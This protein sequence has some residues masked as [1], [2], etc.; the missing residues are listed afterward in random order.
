M[1]IRC[2]TATEALEVAKLLPDVD[3]RREPESALL[4]GVNDAHFGAWGTSAVLDTAQQSL[5]S[6]RLW[7]LAIDWQ[8]D[9]SGAI[10]LE[11][12]R[13]QVGGQ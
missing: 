8:C 9:G 5:T 11:I 12:R 10:R 2:A 6:R 13:T 7:P 3:L 4:V 1:P